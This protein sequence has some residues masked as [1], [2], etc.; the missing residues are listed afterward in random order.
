MTPI[1]AL[2]AV[3]DVM[4]RSDPTYCAA[5]GLAESTDV[6]WDDALAAA[7]DVLDA[8]ERQDE[9]SVPQPR[10]ETRGQYPHLAD[11]LADVPS[12]RA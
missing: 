12:R 8:R 11:A 4:R 6:E 2:R 3:V 1:E 10:P 5:L 7:E 9:P